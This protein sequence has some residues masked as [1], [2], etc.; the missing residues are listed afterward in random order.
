MFCIKKHEKFA[1]RW[2][3]GLLLVFLIDFVSHRAEAVFKC[4]KG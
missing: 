2:G 4:I 1:N 3:N